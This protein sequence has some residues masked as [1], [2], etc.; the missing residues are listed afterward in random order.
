MA[1]WQGAARQKL[2]AFV[3]APS[4]VVF[5]GRGYHGYWLFNEPVRVGDGDDRGRQV[6]LANMMLEQRLHGDSVSDL[7]RVLRVAGTVNPK[8]NVRCCLLVEDG[9]TY[10]FDALIRTLD[11]EMSTVDTPANPSSTTVICGGT[12]SVPAQERTQVSRRLWSPIAR[13]DRSRSTGPASLGTSPCRW[14]GLVGERA[15]PASGWPRPVTSGSCS[16]RSDG[17]SRVDRDAA[18][19][20]VQPPRLAHRGSV[21]GVGDAGA[22]LLATDRRKGQVSDAQDPPGSRCPDLDKEPWRDTC[23]KPQMT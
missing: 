14:R 3:P 18:R 1:D 2:M 4:L 9:P 23:Q 13:G 12:A 16:R 7:A 15:L 8:T 11:V 22:G 17:A 5:S 21:S 20:S 10:D 19:G 6:V